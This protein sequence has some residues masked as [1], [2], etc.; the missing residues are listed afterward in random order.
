MSK[1][2][3]LWDKIRQ[4]VV[5]GMSTAAEKTEELTRL[6]KAKLDVLAIKRKISKQFTE[7]GGLAYEASKDKKPQEAFKT[8][9]VT[10][11][12]DTITVLEAELAEKEAQFEDLKKSAE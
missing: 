10:V 1:Q 6:G 11:I 9:E 8:P 4:S 7:L 12:I 2:K 5:E 3:M